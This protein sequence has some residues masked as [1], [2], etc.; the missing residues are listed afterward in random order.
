MERLDRGLGKLD[1]GGRGGLEG[2]DRRLGKL[3]NGE[4]WRD[5]IEV[6]ENWIIGEF[7]RTEIRSEG[8]NFGVYERDI[9]KMLEK[10]S[11]KGLRNGRGR[12]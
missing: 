5:W 4:G 6:W 9:R 7:G 1:Y 8:L 10:C 11:M 3:G 2:L 12:G